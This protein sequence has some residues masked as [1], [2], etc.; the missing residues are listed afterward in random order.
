MFCSYFRHYKTTTNNR[1]FTAALFLKDVMLTD[2]RGFR[3]AAL[4]TPSCPAFVT[5]PY[6]Q[7]TLPAPCTF[8]KAIFAA[9][10]SIKDCTFLTTVPILCCRNSDGQTLTQRTTHY[11]RPQPTHIPLHERL[12]QY[13]HILHFARTNLCLQFL[14]LTFNQW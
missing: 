2:Q 5:T 14:E 11:A 4:L 9:P 13:L 12:L 1:F 6:S 10:V 3:L 7:A 8:P